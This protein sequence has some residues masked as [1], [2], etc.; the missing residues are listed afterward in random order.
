ML[1]SEI[2]ELREEIE[3]RLQISKIKMSQGLKFGRLIVG[4]LSRRNFLRFLIRRCER[5][6]SKLDNHVLQQFLAAIWLK[7]NFKV[8]IFLTLTKDRK[9][10]CSGLSTLNAPQC[11]HAIFDRYVTLIH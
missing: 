5:R 11:F 9:I 6:L 1:V 4:Y 7:I 10:V 3:I 2:A 8:K